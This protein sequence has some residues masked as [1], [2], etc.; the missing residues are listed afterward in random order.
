MFLKD[1]PLELNVSS[2][3]L[4]KVAENNGFSDAVQWLFRKKEGK[5]V[6]SSLSELQV[7]LS[8]AGAHQSEPIAVRRCTPL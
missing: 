8:N 7:K 6:F 2:Y 1:L 5:K 4:D 3:V